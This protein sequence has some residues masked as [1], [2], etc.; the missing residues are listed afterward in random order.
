LL[1]LVNQLLELSKLEAGQ[2]ELQLK[3]GELN[4]FVRTMVL[5][6][7]SFA[8][9]KN[10]DFQTQFSDEP[11]LVYFD[12]DKLEKII[13]NLLANAFKFCPEGGVIRYSHQL[14]SSEEEEKVG[15]QFEVFDSGK[16]ISEEEKAFIFQRFYSQ[17]DTR[18]N[19]DGMGIGL[20]LVKELID[21]FEG[22]IE[23]DSEEGAGSCFRLRLF[24]DKASKAE[25][26]PVQ[27]NQLHIEAEKIDE[28]KKS[29]LLMDKSKPLV[30]LVE[31]NADMRN[32]L[33]EQLEPFFSILLAKDGVEG[34]EMAQEHIPDLIVS[35]WMMPHMPGTRLLEEIRKDLRS[36]HIPLIMLTAKSD[37]QDLMEGIEKGADAYLSKPFEI[38][39]LKLRI[40]KLIER[41]KILQKAY[42]KIA[43]KSSVKIH[44]QEISSREELFLQKLIEIIEA[45]LDDED[46]SIPQLGKE[47][48]MSRSQLHRKVKA[49]TDKSPSAFVR[50]I[51]MK[52]AHQLL[53]QKGGNISEVAF[54]VGIPNLSYFSR[55]FRDEFGYPPS[56]LL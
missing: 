18:Y 29:F 2:M 1:S 14:I 43:D 28:W 34:L 35:D 41:Q 12:S 40:T 32:Y 47:V 48:G 3:A 44:P 46:F 5:A 55:S 53:E 10:I 26:I 38:S 31:D 7:E 23:I 36:S 52:H 37:Q 13:S 17:S 21:L 11:I 49:L 20:A 54:Q 6:F 51:R 50:S 4:T 22:K 33:K 8:I 24:F 27:K 25:A 42:S 56:D 39:E 15:I 30:L 16:G 45:H 9:R 19:R